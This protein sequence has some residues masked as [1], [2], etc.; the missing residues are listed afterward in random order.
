[1][2]KRVMVFCLTIVIVIMSAGCRKQQTTQTEH[3]MIPVPDES[4][5]VFD[6]VTMEQIK[7]RATEL[8]N[9]YGSY[10]D[11][12]S[13][14]VGANL[15]LMTDD[16]VSEWRFEMDGNGFRD[17]IG[18]SNEYVDD[19]V[20]YICSLYR[21]NRGTTMRFR[22]EW[23]PLE[24]LFF[25][26]DLVAQAEFIARQLYNYAYEQDE[27]A[28]YNLATYILAEDNP[29]VTEYAPIHYDSDLLDRWTPQGFFMNHIAIF[30]YDELL[31]YDYL[32]EYRD[33]KQIEG[34]LIDYR[35]YY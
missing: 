2:G 12:V 18:V 25:D 16:A 8:S 30:C 21:E 11:M 20:S 13:L 15:N 1:M 3:I 27:C 31:M 5:I 7:E 34:D 4:H 10:E 9:I 23:P 26:D 32:E 22:F 17:Y 35:I 24:T 28:I 14:L 19:Y 33:E 29:N 6:E